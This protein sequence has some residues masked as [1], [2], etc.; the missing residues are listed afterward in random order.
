MKMSIKN[1]FYFLFPA[2]KTIRWQ[3]CILDIR[4]LCFTLE[5]T[6]KYAFLFDYFAVK[7]K[8]R[9]LEIIGQ[10]KKTLGVEEYIIESDRNRIVFWANS[11]R[12][13][14]YALST[15]LQILAFYKKDGCMPGFFIKDAPDISFRGFLLD[16]AHG[17]FPLLPELQRLLLKLALLKF[18]RFCLYLGD[19]AKDEKAAQGEFKKGSS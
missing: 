5:I 14:F 11:Q 13:Q 12:G 15:L 6:K 16:V 2:P 7:N 18:N 3:N 17:A 8:N 19:P 9:G 10:E 4:D 1:E